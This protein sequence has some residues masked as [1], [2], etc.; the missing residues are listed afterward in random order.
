MGTNHMPLEIYLLLLSV[1]SMHGHNIFLDKVD[2]SLPDL[3][4]V[5]AQAASERFKLGGDLLRI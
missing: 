2:D 3:K 1:Q 5:V 4:E